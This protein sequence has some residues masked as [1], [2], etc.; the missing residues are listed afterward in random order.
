MQFV[1]VVSISGLNVTID[2]PLYMPNWNNAKPHGA[3]WGNF[4]IQ[5][6][7]IEDMTLDHQADTNPTTGAIFGIEI[8]DAYNCWV[9]NVRSIIA[10]RA[11]VRFEDAAHS[12]V[13]D[14]YFYGT[15]N[16]QS[17]SYGVESYE[18]SDNLIIN[19]IF[20]HVASG[21]LYNGNVGTVDAYNYGIDD[22]NNFPTFALSSTQFHAAG[23]DM[24]LSEGNQGV[25]I[26]SDV[27]HGTHNF[28]TTFRNFLIGPD[29][30]A[31]SKTS[32]T[33]V[34]DLQSFSRF[35]NIIGNVFGKAGYA[36]T[37]QVATGGST[38]N[39]N[40]AIYNLGFPNDECSSDGASP[41]AVPADPL[42][43]STL[44]RWGNWDVVNNASRFVS[45]EVP[46]GLSQFANP[47]PANN[48]LPTS[49]F[50]VSGGVPYSNPP[51]WW[52]TAYGTPAWPAIGP[53]VTGGTVTSGSGTGSNLGGHVYL[54]P[55]ALCQQNLAQDSTNYPSTVIKAYDAAT[56]YPSE[57]ATAPDSP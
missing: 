13:R 10:N 21:N 45:G 18:S 25:S 19:N 16:L 42:V 5:N 20:H 8:S 15:L 14:N 27:K 41:P 23:E 39:C 51:T 6:S 26:T 33:M 31:P 48:N 36:N 47:V 54:I 22:A 52:A 4:T 17:Q 55:A 11:H 34:V 53:D 29:A 46:S 9:K 56:C 35:Y 44:M 38:S 50:L 24:T 43:S 7:G 3:W 32:N 57:S 28:N 2:T 30:A 12:V 40:T 1:K 49:F 37:Y